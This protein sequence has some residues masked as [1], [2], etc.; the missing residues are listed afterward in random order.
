MTRNHP[1]APTKRSHLTFPLSMPGLGVVVLAFVL[2]GCGPKTPDKGNVDAAIIEAVPVHFALEGTKYEFVPKSPETLK[3]NFSAKLVAKAD[4]YEN[5]ASF[6]A[7]PNVQVLR[8]ALAKGNS[9]PIYGHLMAKRTVDHWDF[10]EATVEARIPNANPIGAADP[11]Q[12][13]LTSSSSFSAKGAPETAQLQRYSGDFVGALAGVPVR[14]PFEEV[15][16][17]QVS[18]EW[19]GDCFMASTTHVSGQPR[20]LV[21]F[22]REARSKT[23]KCWGIGMTGEVSEGT[24]TWNEADKTFVWTVR[25][26]AGRE[27]VK[28]DKFTKPKGREF[29]TVM[30]DA[31][32][33]IASDFRGRVFAQ[34]TEDPLPTPVGPTGSSEDA[35][36]GVSP[37]Q[38]HPVGVERESLGYVSRGLDENARRHFAP[39]GNGA[40][41]DVNGVARETQRP[42]AGGSPVAQAQPP[43]LTPFSDRSTME[44]HFGSTYKLSGM[45]RVQ[46]VYTNS[47][48]VFPVVFVPDRP[49]KVVL[50]EEDRSSNAPAPPDEAM[51]TS[52]V[53]ADP[54]L[55]PAVTA[56][57]G[58]RVWL[59][60]VLSSA[61]PELIHS[62]DLY[63]SKI[64]VIER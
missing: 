56:A 46:K 32:G 15:P 7:W 50:T 9:L 64:E 28:T 51:T 3:I 39:M 52:V 54:N 34:G 44:V 24:G 53:K 40:V 35:S 31:G 11:D 36:T 58:K 10:S 13:R 59:T 19:I 45:L 43:T 17:L 18:S 38:S 47:G 60:F 21:F 1:S 41:P 6:V 5:L 27:T 4:L 16:Q 63:A 55:E 48:T 62:V 12:F 23:Y 2:S 20:N 14:D 8:L 25:D 26:G 22:A 61:V 57:E 33:A 30:R 42:G 49:L 37:R 29:H